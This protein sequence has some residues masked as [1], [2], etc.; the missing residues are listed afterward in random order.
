MASAASVVDLVASA[1]SVASVA[2]LV[3]SAASVAWEDT[4]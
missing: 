3:A 1:A 4:A 2:D